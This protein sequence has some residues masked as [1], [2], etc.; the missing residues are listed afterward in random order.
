MYEDPLDMFRE[1]DALFAGFTGNPGTG[2]IRSRCRSAP[3]W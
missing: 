1:M 3:D 2:N